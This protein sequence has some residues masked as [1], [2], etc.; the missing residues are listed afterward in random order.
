MRLVLLRSEHGKSK[1]D[2]FRVT[3]TIALSISRNFYTLKLSVPS[4]DPGRMSGIVIIWFEIQLAYALASSTLSASRSFMEGFNSGFGFGFV[5]EDQI[6]KSSGANRITGKSFST[7]K[8]VSA[9]KSSNNS[10]LQE[11][12]ISLPYDFADLRSAGSPDTNA[13]IIP[14]AKDRADLNGLR[15]SEYDLDL[16]GYRDSALLQA[17]ACRYET[18]RANSSLHSRCNS[19][20]HSTTAAR[21]H[22]KEGEGV[23]MHVH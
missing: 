8:S 22:D 19:F 23:S 9:Q 16:E 3:R 14:P 10:V 17:V 4:T 13:K 15:A 5:R 18:S 20:N 1:T 11:P 2:I 12:T 6:S 7:A 21:D